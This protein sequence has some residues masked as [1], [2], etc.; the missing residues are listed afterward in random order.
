MCNYSGANIVI[1]F[2]I[3]KYSQKN[4]AFSEIYTIFAPQNYKNETI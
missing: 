3:T 1:F 2:N 4:F